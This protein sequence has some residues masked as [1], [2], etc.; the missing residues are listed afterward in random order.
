MFLYVVSTMRLFVKYSLQHTRE[1]LSRGGRAGKT[2]KLHTF[3]FLSQQTCNSESSHLAS[4]SHA[5]L[6][7]N[8]NQGQVCD[9]LSIRRREVSLINLSGVPAPPFPRR[10]RL[11]LTYVRTRRPHC[12]TTTKLLAF[13]FLTL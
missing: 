12:I 3:T 7:F 4:G 8:G 11:S 1:N 13:Y 5:Q 9:A 2:L 6:P 10:L